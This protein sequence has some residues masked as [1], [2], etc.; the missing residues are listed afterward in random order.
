MSESVFSYDHR[1]FSLWERLLTQPRVVVQYVGLL[2]YPHPSRLNLAHDV[3]VSHSLIDPVTTLFSLVA[4]LA[5]FAL[6]IRQARAFPLFSFC[7]LWFFIHLAIESSIFP[8]EMMFEHR[9]YL[10]VVGFSLAAASLLHSSAF[11]KSSWAVAAVIAL[12]AVGALGL[13]TYARNET[14]RDELTLW[15]DAV[16]KSPEGYRAHNNLGTAL[17]A[18]GQPTEAAAHLSRSIELNPDYFPPHWNL[19]AI[20]KD[21]GDT[22]ALIVHLRGALALNPKHASAHRQLARALINTGDWSGALEHFEEAVRL[23][24]DWPAALVALAWVLANHPDPNTRAPQR[25]IELAERADELT[26][27]S[28]HHILNTLATAYKVAKRFEDAARIQRDLLELELA[29]GGPRVDAIRARLE[30]FEEFEEK[31]AAFPDR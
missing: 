14:W 4:L 12:V 13:G 16:S 6:A 7:T 1:N 8:L 9:L 5:L 26:E 15:S 23:G 3:P 19:A 29:D 22:D 21:G 24:P 11:N 31:A 17:R 18:A 20:A 2:L 27:H 30:E 25:A 10:P 28:K